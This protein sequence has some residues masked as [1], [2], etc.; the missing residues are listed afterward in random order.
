M[1]ASLAP[2]NQHGCLTTSRAALAPLDR[3][4]EK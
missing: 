1:A 2:I 4:A 3:L